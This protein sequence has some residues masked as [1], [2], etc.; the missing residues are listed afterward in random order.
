MGIL[1]V[2]RESD[3]K[4]VNHARA[5]ASA[6]SFDR[7]KALGNQFPETKIFQTSGFT[8]HACVGVQR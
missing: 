1:W 6:Q 5:H 2:K 8:A 3:R 4:C 7:C